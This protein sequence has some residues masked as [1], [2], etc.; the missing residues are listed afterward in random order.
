MKIKNIF[1]GIS[2]YENASVSSSGGVLGWFGT[3]LFQIIFM[4]ISIIGLIGSFVSC[5][6]FIIN[7][8]ILGIGTLIFILAF[9]YITLSKK[10]ILTII[11]AWLIAIIIGIFN[12]KYV[13]NG[14]IYMFN[15]I[16]RGVNSYLNIEIIELTTVLD[17]GMCI[18]SLLL[19]FIFIIIPINWFLLYRSRCKVIYILVS[20]IFVAVG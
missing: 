15:S 13:L 20:F 8:S 16:I 1:N 19:M 9:I 17:E 4:S 6:D 12:W 3:L 11:I 7:S 5:F 14:S 10:P 2:I 18:S